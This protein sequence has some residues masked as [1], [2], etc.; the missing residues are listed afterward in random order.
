MATPYTSIIP[1]EI[2]Q[3]FT[4]WKILVNFIKKARPSKRDAQKRIPQCCYT[5]AHTKGERIRF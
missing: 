4:R 3:N 1:Y 5:S 2:G